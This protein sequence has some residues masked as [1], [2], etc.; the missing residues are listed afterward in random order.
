MGTITISVDNDTEKRFREAVKKKLGERKGYLGKATTEAL[1]LWIQ[2]Q[3][4][5]EIARDAL[6][7]LE[8][9]HHLGKHLYKERKDLY[10][11]TTSSY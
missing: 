9:G 3:T 4:Q 11:R 5:E 7:L 8:K 1:D 10:D 2:K 6:A